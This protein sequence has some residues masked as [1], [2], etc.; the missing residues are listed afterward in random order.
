VTQRWVQLTGRPV[1]LDA[2]PW[3]DAPSG[4]TSEI[5]ASFFH[6]LAAREGLSVDDRSSPRGL[7]DDFAALAGPCCRVEEVHPEVVRFYERTSEY[8]L[9]VWSEWSPLFRPFGWLLALLFSRRLQ[10]LNVPL[11]PLDTA[12]GVT[13]TVLKLRDAQ[14]KTR[15]TA[16]VRE[17]VGSRRTLYVGSYG[18]CPT[19]LEPNASLRVIFPLPNGSAIV[20]MRP[21]SAPD[22]S[23]TVSSLGERFG[24]AGFYFYVR[25][26]ERAGWARAVRTL[27]E[28]IRVFVDPAGELRADHVLRIF[29]TPFLRL[30]YRM[31]RST[32]IARPLAGGE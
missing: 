16:W 15:F 20:V 9:D 5:G 14:G 29:G 32:T 21:E 31:R 3:L 4:E 26:S 8:Q 24:G 10:Q 17:L 11:A 23:L 22:G 19:P 12:L 13:N 30:H 6:E 25:R 7:L 1:S 27:K 28:S 2:D 18:V